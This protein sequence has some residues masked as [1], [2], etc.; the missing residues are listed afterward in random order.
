MKIDVMQ[1]I[2][3]LMSGKPV[4]ENDPTQDMEAK[5]ESQAPLDKRDLIVGNALAS[6]LLHPNAVSLDGQRPKPD[7]VRKRYQLAR[8]CLDTVEAGSKKGAKPADKSVSLS[9]EEAKMCQDC[10]CIVYTS[11]SISGPLCDILDGE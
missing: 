5:Q 6:A 9:A 11:G 8:K 10:V 4:K 2:V 1:P 3:N 7:Q